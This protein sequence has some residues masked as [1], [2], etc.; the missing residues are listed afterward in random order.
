MFSLNKDTILFAVAAICFLAVIY[1]YREVQKIKKTPMPVFQPA[2]SPAPVH[3]TPR[4]VPP[5][6]VPQSA[7][8][9]APQVV[10]QVKPVPASPQVQEKPDTIVTVEP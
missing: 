6:F 7:P 10:P 5:Q 1:L 9:S 3:D 2:P 8:Q 4:Y